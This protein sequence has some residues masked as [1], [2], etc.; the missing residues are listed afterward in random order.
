MSHS[1]AIVIYGSPEKSKKPVSLIRDLLASGWSYND[2]GY[3]SYL[4]LGDNDEMDWQR[5]ALDD[6]PAIIDL[7]EGKVLCNELIGLSLIHGKTSGG[8]LLIPSNLQT[9]TMSLTINRRILPGKFRMTDYS[10]YLER[11]LPPLEQTGYTI[12]RVECSDDV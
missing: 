10:W 7:I 1:A 5:G 12:E 8:E 11:L 3:I 2:S 9:I 4:P 6:W